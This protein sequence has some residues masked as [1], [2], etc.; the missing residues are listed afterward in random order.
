MKLSK[1]YEPSKY[2]SDIYALWEQSNAFIPSEAKDPY[3]IVVPPPNANGNLHLGHALTT[4]IQDTLIRYHRLQGKSAVYIPGADHA[5]FETQVVY[6]K[7]LEQEGKSRFDFTREELF[8][9]IWKFVENNKHNMLSQMRALGA[10]VDWSRFVYTLDERVVKTAYATFKKLWEDGLVYRGERLVNYCTKHRTSFAD[11][12]VIYEEHKSPLYYLKYGPFTL[13]TTRPETKFGD[14][15]VAVHPDDSRYKQYV[16]T[17][18]KAEG[19]IGPFEIRVI[20]DEMVDPDFGTG[21]VKIT[22]A[23]DFNDWEVAR[24]HNLEAV[25]VINH[26]GTMNHLAGPFEGMPVEV[27]RTAIAKAL[28]AKGLMEKVDNNYT[29]RV[30]LCYKCGTVIEPMLMDQWFIK[31]QPLAKAAVA[32]IKKNKITF[33]PE[34]KRQV[35]ISY[36]ENLQDWNISRQIVWGIPIP[37]FQNVNDS[38]DWIFDEHVSQEIIEVKGTTYRRD[39]DVFDTWFS[40]GQWPFITMGYPD[41]NDYSRYYPLSVMETGYDILYQ[42]VARM[43]M[44]G[45]YVTGKVPFKD[46]YLHGL[47]LDEKGQKMSKSK[48]NVINP[49]EVLQKYGSDALRMGLIQ[50]RSAGSN[51]PFTMDKVVGARNFAN[52]LWNV[53]RYVEGV[54]GDEYTPGVAQPK[55]AAD[56]WIL[57]RMSLAVKSIADQ[58]EQ[59]RLA[60]AYETLYHLLWNDFA[61]WY[62][63]ISKVAQNPHM[64]AY[65]LQTILVLAHP[66]APFVTETI[67]QSLSWTDGLLIRSQWPKVVRG[68]QALAREFETVKSVIAEIRE[69]RSQ[70]HLRESTLYHKDN[71]FINEN[72]EVITKLSGIAAIEEVQS[73]FGLHLTTPGVDAWLDVEHSVITSYV[74]NLKLQRVLLDDT[75]RNLQSRLE[76]NHYMRRAPKHVIEQTQS[77]HA[78]AKTQLELIDNQIKNAEN[79]L[80]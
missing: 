67:W 54:L 36:L 1:A 72:A 3:S 23:H 44:L 37:A 32:A 15:A 43:I 26:D 57:E 41:G 59:Y 20:A 10:S 40:S 6:E 12:E 62:I 14:T 45:I 52:K 29:N 50:G 22:P 24:R 65:G 74:D 48:G 66:F 53:A 71:A 56:D 46:V 39:Q 47:V 64:L 33:Y 69:L 28:Q 79:S 18:I 51:Q 49:M 8:G 55:N 30:G 21:A 2:E 31:V 5:G 76:N 75:L 9:N 78:T 19:V 68:D 77:Q 27:A 61:D 63:E 35:T 17:V 70:L 73:G 38:D 60:E 42:W 58:I 80:T 25:R 16:N 34:S 7:Q 11:I 13:A 4:A